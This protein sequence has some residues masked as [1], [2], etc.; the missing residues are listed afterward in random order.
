[1]VGMI[2]VT[3]MER[4]TGRDGLYMGVTVLL[5]ARSTSNGFSPAVAFHRAKSVHGIWCTIAELD[6]CNTGLVRRK[7]RL[8]PCD[9]EVC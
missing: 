9:A 8:R 3:A 6:H 4:R 7:G 5:R 2:S 1:M